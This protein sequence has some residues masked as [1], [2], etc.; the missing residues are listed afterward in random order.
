MLT[1]GPVLARRS[2]WILASSSAIGCSKSR[3]FGFI[4]DSLGAVR[5]GAG[6]L[7]QT[8]RGAILAGRRGLRPSPG[9][10]LHAG[11]RAGR[12]AALA[13]RPVQAEVDLADAGQGPQRA[14]QLG[15]GADA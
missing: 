9:A 3:K 15:L 2:S 6:R 13:P 11:G 12:S 10:G 4:G 7:E 1:A 8:L 14:D 5:P